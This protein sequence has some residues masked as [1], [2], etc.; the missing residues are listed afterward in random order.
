[1]PVQGTGG[2]RMIEAPRHE[3]SGSLSLSLSVYVQLSRRSVGQ[4]EITGKDVSM[5]MNNNN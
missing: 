2:S 4:D 1:M 3:Q 5:A